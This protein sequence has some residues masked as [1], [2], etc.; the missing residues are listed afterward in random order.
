M[1]KKITI[2]AEQWVGL[3]AELA[4]WYVEESALDNPWQEDEN[5]DQ[6]YTEEAQM[7]FEDAA[8]AI[9]EILSDFFEKGEL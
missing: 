8:G 5:G 6:S 7:K 3:Y 1:S 2:P 4:G 9:E